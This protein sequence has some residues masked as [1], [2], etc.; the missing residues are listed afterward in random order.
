MRRPRDLLEWAYRVA[1]GQNEE[2]AGGSLSLMG[3]NPIPGATVFYLKSRGLAIISRISRL[4]NVE[5]FAGFI[6][7]AVSA[8][9]PVPAIAITFLST[10]ISPASAAMTAIST[11]TFVPSPNNLSALAISSKG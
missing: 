7:S 5:A 10:G 2:Q 9:L 8:P 6:T 1:R 3:S 4:K 11:H